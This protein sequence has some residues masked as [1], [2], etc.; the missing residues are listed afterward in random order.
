MT[1]GANAFTVTPV[2]ATSLPWTFVIPITAAFEA[3]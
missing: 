3:E 1:A 2:P